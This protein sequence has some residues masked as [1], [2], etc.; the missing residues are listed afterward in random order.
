MYYYLIVQID[1]PVFWRYFFFFFRIIITVIWWSSLSKGCSK[2][3]VV[4]KWYQ[5][6]KYYVPRIKSFVPCCPASR[7]ED[8]G[9]HW[10]I[11]NIDTSDCFAFVPCIYA[12]ALIFLRVSVHIAAASVCLILDSLPALCRSLCW[13]NLFSL[14]GNMWFEAKVL[15][16]LY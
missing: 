10:A 3:V 7:E 9:D 1:H 4:W 6:Y 8:A 13:W 16:Y 11:K 15:R 5:R 2:G 14:E 12:C